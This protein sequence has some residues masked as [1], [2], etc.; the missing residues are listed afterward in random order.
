M[1]VI[2][3][4]KHTN[5]GC[6]VCRGCGA[7]TAGRVNAAN[8]VAPLCQ[9]YAEYLM[10]IAAFACPFFWLKLY[11]AVYSVQAI[12]LRCCR[13]QE[14]LSKA[15]QGM[16]PY[17]DASDAHGCIDYF[18][19]WMKIKVPLNRQQT[20]A[21]RLLVQHDLI[22]RMSEHWVSCREEARAQQ[23]RVPCA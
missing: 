1:L 8:K 10:R 23:C 21:D 4:I 9:R 19:G 14:K 5:S 17:A 7:F 3:R 16:P 13:C 2:D 15:V 18:Y 20:A 6:E 11:V 22:I 12:F